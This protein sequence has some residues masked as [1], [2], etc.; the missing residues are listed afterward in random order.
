MVQNT[1]SDLKINI[2]V[3]GE[4]DVGKTSLLNAYNKNKFEQHTQVTVGIDFV[5]KKI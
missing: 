2:I 3:L 1:S 5:Y 4:S